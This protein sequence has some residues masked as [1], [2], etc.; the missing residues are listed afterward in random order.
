MSRLER[1]RQR[2]QALEARGVLEFHYC[3]APG[4]RYGKRWV[5]TPAG[6]AERVLSTSEL[7]VF[8]LGAESSLS[9]RVTV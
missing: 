9:A 8:M 2:L 7:E 4:D 6:H 3:S 5:L 1:I